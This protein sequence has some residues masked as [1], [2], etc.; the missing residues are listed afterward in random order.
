[1]YA[2]ESSGYSR[3]WNNSIKTGH[4]EM[5]VVTD[6]GVLVIPDYKNDASTVDLKDYNYSTKNGNI[7]DANG[8][9]FNTI[10]TVHTHLDGSLPSTYDGKGFGD[11]GF[12]AYSTP[13]KA[14]F[15]L[16]VTSRDIDPISF[17]ISGATPYSNFRNFNNYDT[18]KIDKEKLNVQMLLKGTSLRG[19]II[20][21]AINKLRKIP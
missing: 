10:T 17:I 18:Y 13:N 6:K 15:V 1:M 19:F 9:Q 4:E 5:G 12:A 16:R 11:L 3:I 2:N 21:N 14:V 20:N 8:N 7:V